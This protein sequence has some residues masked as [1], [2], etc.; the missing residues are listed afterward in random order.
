MHA[1]NLK[2]LV[3]YQ[4]KDAKNVR[5]HVGEQLER[6]G[7]NPN[8]VTNVEE[9]TLTLQKFTELAQECN[10]A[11]AIIVPD[12][13]SAS[14]AG[15]IWFELGYWLGVNSFDTIL[16]C[17]QKAPDNYDFNN[18]GPW[19]VKQISN[20]EGY[21]RCEFQE[22]KDLDVHIVR[23]V[24]KLKDKLK[25]YNPQIRHDENGVYNEQ[26]KIKDSILRGMNGCNPS[27]LQKCP[28]RTGEPECLYRKQS[29]CL[30]AE[31]FRIGR[32][33]KE[34]AAF[35]SCLYRIAHNC[36]QILATNDQDE[37]RESERHSK[38]RQL[39][40]D[41][42]G[43][44]EELHEAGEQLLRRDE[45]YNENP[46]SVW[47]HIERFLEY[48]YRVYKVNQWLITGE[49]DITENIEQCK[50]NVT[51]FCKWAQI[52]NSE[53]YKQT[54]F[55]K[56]GYYQFVNENDEAEMMLTSGVELASEIGH[57]L[58]EQGQL[59]YGQC[60]KVI[61]TNLARITR[62]RNIQE[63]FKEIRKNF[64]HNSRISDLP[65]PWPR[66]EEEKKKYQYI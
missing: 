44:I 54:R 58:T 33:N 32:F 35:E 60:N 48:R 24:N 57:V 66:D 30:I 62:N 42:Q 63:I 15:N 6:A 27:D 40:R 64:P 14:E 25:P 52:V 47:E 9:N 28:D 36:T 3:L 23:F 29:L 45:S 55:Y 51:K 37:L 34:Y 56:E 18:S 7:V 50:E 17:L 53:I 26:L 49:S 31:L 38:R 11:V 61:N 46:M 1:Q 20:L 10:G 2:I 8:R 13:R 21:P 19:P 4:G 41:L 39:M 59:Y 65:R 16:M 5:Q 12:E 22:P 43:L